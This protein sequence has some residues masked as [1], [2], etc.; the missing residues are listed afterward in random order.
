MEPI[1]EREGAGFFTEREARCMGEAFVKDVVDLVGYDA[2][3]DAAVTHR[4]QHQNH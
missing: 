3:V 2:L 4:H 1:R